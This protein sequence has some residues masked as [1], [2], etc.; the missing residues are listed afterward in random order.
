MWLSD[1]E[2]ELETRVLKQNMNTSAPSSLNSQ[3]FGVGQDIFQYQKD[4]KS[5]FFAGKIRFLILETK[6]Q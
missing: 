1:L 4:I 5:Q 6:Y 2:A 3:G